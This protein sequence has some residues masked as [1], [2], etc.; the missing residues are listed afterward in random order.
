MMCVSVC[1]CVI[2]CEEGKKEDRACM[3][4]LIERIQIKINEK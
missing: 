4:L 2:S 3:A 1:V